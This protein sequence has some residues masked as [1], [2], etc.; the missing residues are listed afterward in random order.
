M[1]M[2]ELEWMQTFGDNLRDILDDAHMSQSELADAIGVTQA[3][4]SKYIHGRTMPSAKVL[5]NIA[6]VLDVDI[7]DIVYF[8]DMVE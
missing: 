7:F 6:H 5:N 4:I 1:A 2:S 8:G 3:A